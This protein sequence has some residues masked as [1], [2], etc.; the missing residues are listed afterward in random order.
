MRMVTLLRYF[1]ALPNTL[2]GV[3]FV[4]FVVATNGRM[5]IVD[6]ALE[7]RGRLIATILRHGVPIPGGA[8]AMTFG[9]VILGRDSVSLAA[10]RAHERV[11]IEQCERWGPAFIPAYLLAALWGATV[12][13]GP[14]E[15]NY[16]ERQAFLREQR[17]TGKSTCDNSERPLLRPPN[18]STS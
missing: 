14:Y 9:H 1:W 3:L 2:I 6:G 8:A 5:E 17:W 4:P 11:H 16:F 10:T 13:A 7:L 15:G 18:T 12:G